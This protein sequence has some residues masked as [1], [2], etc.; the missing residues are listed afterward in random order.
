MVREL[1][2]EDAYLK[3]SQATVTA[4]GD[5]GIEFDATIFYP[6]GGGQPGDTGMLSHADGRSWRVTDTRKGEVAGS[7]VH[8]LDPVGGLP[9][10]A[11]GDVLTLTL[12]WARR[13]AH[14][15]LHTSMHLLC[16]L[17]PAQ[18]TGG[19]IAADRARLDFAEL[20]LRDGAEPTKENIES[21]L[22]ALIAR[23]TPTRTQWISDEEMAARPEMVRTMSVKPPSGQGRVRL[24]EIEGIDLQPCGG[25]HVANTGE[26]GRVSVT[27]IENKGKQNRRIN[28][29]FA[30]ET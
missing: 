18:A 13:Y 15:R 20:S 17:V 26:I 30:P 4:I 24:M 28:L 22:N 23:A 27:K 3:A 19:N 6:L 8:I 21:R 2:R 7:I 29:A 9:P 16:S 14:M 12:D 10:P 25:T 5:A 11:V 1:F